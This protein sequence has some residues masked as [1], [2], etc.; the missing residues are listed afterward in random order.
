MTMTHSGDLLRG[1]PLCVVLVF[2]ATDLGIQRGAH[3]SEPVTV[4]L[5]SGERYTG[6]VGERTDASILWLRYG[7]Q[8][9]TVLRPIERSRI[10]SLTYNGES[11]APMTI[12]QLLN[13][14]KSRAA[15][16]A[17]PSLPAARSIPNFEAAR[18]ESSFAD[19]ARS[20][21]GFKNREIAD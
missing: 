21:L 2:I 15:D 5:E 11:V 9:T 3:A 20:A 18:R 6:F 4:E 10:A 12:P 17:G 1:I 13:E 19:R 7:T 16:F 14:L 8:Q